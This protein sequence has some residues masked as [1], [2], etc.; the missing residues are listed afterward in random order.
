M[1]NNFS[2]LLY[3]NNMTFKTVEEEHSVSVKYFTDNMSI[4]DY[5]LETMN[6]KFVGKCSKK[7]GYVI[8]VKSIKKISSN[9]ISSINCNVIFNVL[10]ELDVVI[11]EINKIYEGTICLIFEKGIFLDIYNVF[12]VLISFKS[13]NDNGYIYD[14]MFECFKNKEENMLMVGNVVNVQ[15]KGIKYCGDKFNCFGELIE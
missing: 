8:N 15:L 5:I 4:N 14:N 12:K 13:L 2:K 9:K 1:K 3:N 6:K 11:P 10:V 7:N